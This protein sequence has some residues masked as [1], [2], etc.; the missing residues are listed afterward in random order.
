MCKTTTTE[1]TKSIGGEKKIDK[2][3]IGR[4]VSGETKTKGKI[5]LDSSIN[6]SCGK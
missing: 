2:S 6:K 1:I 5:L 3:K 4:Q